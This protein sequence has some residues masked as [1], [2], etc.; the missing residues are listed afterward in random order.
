MPEHST[1][2]MYLREERKVGFVN[3]NKCVQLRVLLRSNLQSAGFRQAVVFLL[4]GTARR[5]SGRNTDLY[6]RCKRGE[7][8][9]LFF[10][11][12]IR[13]RRIHSSDYAMSW[14]A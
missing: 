6:C 12:T 3:A 2:G 4:T 14:T 1:L 8:T 9:R 10:R 7:H 5:I 11:M 13:C